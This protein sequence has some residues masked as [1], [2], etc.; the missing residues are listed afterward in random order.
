M[1]KI[2]LKFSILIPNL[3]YSP[4]LFE[5]LDSVV[6]QQLNKLFD[7]EIIICDQSD[8]DIFD[9]IKKEISERYKV[10]NLVLLH[11][12]IKSSYQAR[13]TLIQHAKDDYICFIDSDD[14]IDKNY[15][16]D[17]YSIII[18][19]DC[20]DIVFTNYLRT[21]TDGKND[22]QVSYL[23][24]L[25]KTRLYDYLRYSVCINAVCCKVF[26]RVLYNAKDYEKY[27]CN[28]IKC[29]DDKVLFLPI[30][31]SASSYYFADN[32]YHYHYRN[33]PDSQ[34][35]N[36]S[37]YDFDSW[38]ELMYINS[39][40][41]KLDKFQNQLLL[42]YLSKNYLSIS[43]KY[44]RDIKFKDFKNRCD[45]LRGVYKTFNVKSDLNV[46]FKFIIFRILIILKQYYFL[47]FLGL[48]KIT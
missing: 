39:D 46:R 38:I 42:V 14:F 37:L 19:N 9:K 28:F 26:K 23:Q 48:I 2:N 22:T 10:S 18:N 45:K 30:L 4:Y 17:L 24:E 25:D 3:G 13:H 8:T 35:K 7:Y 43:P 31:K 36:H 11:S 29:G 32:F 20:P 41:T 16:I 15:L 33:T 1:N 12:N 44:N 47:Y 34:V 27:K 6:N 5:C 40:T 21:T